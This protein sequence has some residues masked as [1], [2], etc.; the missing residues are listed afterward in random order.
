MKIT[1]EAGDKVTVYKG[2]ITR[3][4]DEPEV[5]EIGAMSDGGKLSRTGTGRLQIEF[6]YTNGPRG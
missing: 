3:F 5:F 4:V 6:T 2:Q 1:I